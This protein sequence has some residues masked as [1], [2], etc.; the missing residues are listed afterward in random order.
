MI[1][2][3]LGKTIFLKRKETEREASCPFAAAGR[4]RR[5]LE[6]ASRHQ[7]LVPSVSASDSE[8]QV[9]FVWKSLTLALW[10]RARALWVSAAFE[11]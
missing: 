1:E 8:M 4:L 10:W 6:A 5:H 7:T 3:K 9:Y 2:G 11:R